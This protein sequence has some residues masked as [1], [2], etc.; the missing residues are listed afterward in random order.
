MDNQSLC[1]HRLDRPCIC[2]NNSYSLGNKLLIAAG[3]KITG[4]LIHKDYALSSSR[5]YIT[6]RTKHSKNSQ[7]PE[8][9]QKNSG[10][11]Q[12]YSVLISSALVFLEASWSL[13]TAAPSMAGSVRRH[14]S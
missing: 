6:G 1:V 2:Q 8:G 3:T 9:K 12:Y 11:G 14:S 13:G 7:L 4:T 5:F 10:Y